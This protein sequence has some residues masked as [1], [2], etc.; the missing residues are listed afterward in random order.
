MNSETDTSPDLSIPNI[1]GGSGW[2]KA[3]LPI[4]I[5]ALMGSGVVWWLYPG[6]FAAGWLAAILVPWSIAIGSLALMLIAGLTGGEWARAVWPWLSIQ[7]R[8][9]PWIGLA[10]LLVLTGLNSLYPWTQ[11]SYLAPFENTEHRQWFYQPW[12]FSAR[13]I[14]YW[15]VW[16]GL[17]LLPARQFSNE[18]EHSN[19]IGGQG[20]AGLSLVVLVLT[21]TWASLDWVLSF[22]LFFM[23]TLFGL[24]IGMGA[25]LAGISTTV[26]AVNF[27]RTEPIHLPSEKA[28]GDLGNLMLAM[29]MLWA[30]FSFAQFLI[31]WS[32]DLPNEADFY[33]LRNSGG[34]QLASPLLALLGFVVPFLCL[35][36]R[37]FKLSPGKIGVLAIALILVRQVELFWMIFPATPTE[38]QA[39]LIW[40]VP[41]A[42]IAVPGLYWLGVRRSM[43]RYEVQ[44]RKEISHDE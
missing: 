13:T 4:T 24:L 20:V 33:Q 34:W 44:R 39:T 23:S 37:D 15:F 25:L 26:A 1:S 28:R 43:S 16:S 10:F 14:F 18:N 41:P 36:S 3:L 9:I 8:F 30:Y 11:E 31:M 27:W 21:V 12:F 7:I 32:G 40:T 17:S 38:I 29:L 2:Q 22:D 5:L 35:L 19:V 42:V 6:A